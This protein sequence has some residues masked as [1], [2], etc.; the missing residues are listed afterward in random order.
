VKQHFE[1][2]KAGVPVTSM[3]G[4]VVQFSDA[5]LQGIAERYDP[6]L[7]EAPLI[8]GHPQH[9]T[10]AY[11]WVRGLAFA[12][13]ALAVEEHQVDPAFAQLRSKGSYKK[14]SARFYTPTSKNNPTPG[15]YYLRDVGFLGAMAPAVKGLRS[16]SF[17]DDAGDLVTAEVSFADLP[18]YAG[19]YIGDLFRG[20]RDFVIERFGKDTADKVLP[21]WQVQ[22]LNN[23]SVRAEATENASLGF[24][25]RV[26]PTASKEKPHMKTTEQLQ[27]EVDAANRERDAARTRADTLEKADRER[28]TA[29]V[30]RDNVSFADELIKGARWPAGA[31]E[32]LVATLDHLA[33]PPGEGAVV[34]FGDGDAA[35]PLHQVLREQLQAL[36]E[37]VSFGEFAGK[38]SGGGGADDDASTVAAKAVIYQAE[39]AKN[40]N[41]ITTAEA[42]RHVSRK[43]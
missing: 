11:G 23:I 19:G 12:D 9:D 2:F 7:H 26:P 33:T 8:V 17:A 43:S 27:A 20:L 24:A 5:D 31:K 22:S 18:A 41:Q 42:V 40:G 14:V 3:E 37:Q 4:A 30:H 15:Q 34:S 10:P 28:A 16:A 6:K 38:G 1:I 35:K 29:A 32:V 21:D 13:G 36:P 25:D 39:Q